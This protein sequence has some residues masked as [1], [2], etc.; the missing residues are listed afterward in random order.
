LSDE[1]HH[2]PN[3]DPLS[4][5]SLSDLSKNDDE[6]QWFTIDEENIEFNSTNM[7][8]FDEYA[9]NKSYIYILLLSFKVIDFFL[10]NLNQRKR[11]LQQLLSC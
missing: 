2:R 5:S 6:N 1:Q 10:E 11:R 3:T 7:F 8:K 4:S 9:S